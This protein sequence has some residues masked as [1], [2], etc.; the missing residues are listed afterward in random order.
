MQLKRI[1]NNLT[2]VCWDKC[3]DKVGTSLGRQETCLQNCA[4]RFLDVDQFI[5]MRMSNSKKQ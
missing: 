4:E 5:R 3:V 1:V 2:V